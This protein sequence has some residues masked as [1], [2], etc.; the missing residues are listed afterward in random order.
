MGR[1]DGIKVRNLPT[2]RQMMPF[3]LRT[4][5][6]ALITWGSDVNAQ[7]GLEF[8]ERMS[9]EYGIKV[10]YFH[11]V[12][13]SIFKSFH[14]FP[15]VNR[16]T[17]GGRIWQRNGI[18]FSF[19]VKKEMSTK[20]SISIVK[21]EFKPD[22][23]LLDT[24]KAA[25]KD[26][27]RARKKDHKDEGEKEAAGY[28]WF[29]AFLIKLGYPFYK[30]MDEY[31]LFT[32]NYMEREVLYASAFIANV[33]SLGLSPPYH[34]LYEVGTINQ[35]VAMGKIEEKPILENGEVVIRKMCPLTVSIDERATDGYYYYK[36]FE[37]FKEQLENPE[38]LLEPAE[39]LG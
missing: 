20:G 11:L 23:T 21:R 5:Q 14:A 2:Y 25:R 34:H 31:G 10:T 37:Y 6:E 26:I 38:K 7:P 28:L 12:L 29:P 13:H 27:S 15:E 24:V 1:P 8:A 18:W 16:F 35:F 3:F 33:G 9:E 4:K 17:K 30:F 19:S 39:I 36:A 32:K 22:F